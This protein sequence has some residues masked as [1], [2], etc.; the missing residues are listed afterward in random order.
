MTRIDEDDAAGLEQSEDPAAGAEG[1][2]QN[3]GKENQAN[4]QSNPSPSLLSLFFFSL[5]PEDNLPDFVVGNL[6]GHKRSLEVFFY[7]K[8]IRIL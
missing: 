3:S 2:A 6:Y 7:E 4:G 1:K 8:S 5:S